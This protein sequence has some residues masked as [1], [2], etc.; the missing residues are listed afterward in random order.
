MLELKGQANH[1]SG[2]VTSVYPKAPPA[3]P[4]VE[5]ESGTLN[6]LKNTACVPNQIAIIIETIINIALDIF[7]LN[8][9]HIKFII[10]IICALNSVVYNISTAFP[11]FNITF[12]D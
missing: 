2:Q 3:K 11:D 4:N 9:L 10:S 1:S 6:K 5:K 8:K 7:S 12:E